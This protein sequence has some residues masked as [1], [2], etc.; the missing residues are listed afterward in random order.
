MVA[1]SKNETNKEKAADGPLNSAYLTFG[2]A[3]S[4]D[5]SSIPAVVLLPRK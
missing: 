5:F 4:G 3:W 1:R 2:A